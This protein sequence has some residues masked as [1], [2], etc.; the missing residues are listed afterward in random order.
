MKKRR[1]LGW[2]IEGLC[3]I[4]ALCSAWRIIQLILNTSELGRKIWLIAFAPTIIG[5]VLFLA[6]C[7]R[8][9]KSK[10]IEDVKWTPH[11]P[12][13]SS[14]AQAK[15][16]GGHAGSDSPYWPSKEETPWKDT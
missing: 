11:A 3:A 5:F 7:E 6:W 15:H 16:D 1:V 10:D 8:R 12:R 2:I 4:A 13:V 9:H 14:E